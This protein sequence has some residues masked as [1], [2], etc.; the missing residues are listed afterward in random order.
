MTTRAKRFV[1]VAAV[2]VTIL[3]GSIGGIYYLR[4]NFS[5]EIA[6]RIAANIVSA[7][8]TRCVDTQAWTHLSIGM[9]REAVIALLG[10]APS[11]RQSS[12][13]SAGDDEAVMIEYWEYNYSS[14]L[15]ASAPHSKAYVVY[16]D[17]TSKVSGFRPPTE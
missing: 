7:H 17:R 5:Q 4:W 14:A 2:L 8:A 16:F 15:G 13:K 12:S 9:S 1:I 10:D 11:K 3:A 6:H